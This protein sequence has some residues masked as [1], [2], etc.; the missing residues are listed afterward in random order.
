MIKLFTMVK[1]ECD[2]ICDWIL[3]H[4]S[5]FGFDNLFIIDNMSCDGTFEIIN[6]YSEKG[7]NIYRESDYKNKG[8]LMKNL[9]DGNCSGNDVAFPIDIDE[10][11]VYHEVGWKEVSCN[12]KKINDYIHGLGNSGIIYKANY[13]CGI[14]T[15]EGGYER[16]V[17]ENQYAIYSDYGTNAKSFFRVDLYKGDID[18]G[19]HI[20]NKDGYFMSNICLVHFHCRNLEQMKKKVLNN[21]IGLGYSPDLNTLRNLINLNPN[22]AGNHHVKHQINIL[23]DNYNINVFCYDNS[24]I[25][26]NELNNYLKNI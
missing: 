8:N 6:K 2:I 4:G 10:F 23:E 24:M 18:H 15:H 3:Y 25:N 7:I 19:N 22:C 12:K 16:A 26:L 20:S 11:I 9:I 17:C 5:L 21:V 14:I 13:I 1:D